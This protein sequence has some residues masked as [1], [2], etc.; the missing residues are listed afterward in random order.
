MAVAVT[1]TARSMPIGAGL[2]A[3]A[4]D[5]PLEGL[6]KVTTPPATGSKLALAVTVAVRLWAKA[7][8][9]GAL[10]RLPPVT[11]TVKPWLSKAPMS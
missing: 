7:M 1:L 11:V 6:A 4:A 8:L 10:W 3:N 2:T 5:A 9:T